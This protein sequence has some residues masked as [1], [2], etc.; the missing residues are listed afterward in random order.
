MNTY[1]TFNVFKSKLKTY[2]LTDFYVI[3]IYYIFIL[4]FIF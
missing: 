4:F 1:F 3:I 2:I